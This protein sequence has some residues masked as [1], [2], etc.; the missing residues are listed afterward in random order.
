MAPVPLE[1]LAGLAAAVLG[2]LFVLD[3]LKLRILRRRL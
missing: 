1:L 2:M 3:F